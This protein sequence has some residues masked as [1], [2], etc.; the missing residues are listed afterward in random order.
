[1][2]D[3]DVGVQRGRIAAADVEQALVDR[4][5]AVQAQPL[6][7]QGQVGLAG[8]HQPTIEP[9]Q[10][11]EVVGHQPQRG[12]W[13]GAQGGAAGQ[14]E[15]AVTTLEIEALDAGVV[16][17]EHQRQFALAQADA[18]QHV[19]HAQPAAAHGAVDLGRCQRAGE[20]GDGVECARQPPARR[21][22][23]AP[24]AQVG[25]PGL[26]NALQRRM[27]R[28]PVALG[29]GAQHLRAG[30]RSDAPAGQ[31]LRQLPQ[32]VVGAQR[33]PQVGQ[34]QR[35]GLPQIVGDAEVAAATLEH[36]VGIQPVGAVDLD[37][38]AQRQVA[39]PAHLGL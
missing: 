37:A 7:V 18:L 6:G 14:G 34:P 36:D 24:H 32:P 4:E 8:G 35:P 13:L 26:Q 25:H 38:P 17:F 23:G 20:L 16:A 19:A 39:A 21:N 28:R 30:Q 12:P 3:G 10:H 31:A 1:M 15:L 11:A 5:G 22:P 27:A 33:H 2:G 29:C 9:A